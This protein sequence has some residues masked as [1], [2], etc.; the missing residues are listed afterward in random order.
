MPHTEFSV[1]TDIAAAPERVWEVLTDIHGSPNVL[2]GVQRVDVLTDGPYAV[3]TRWRETRKIMGMSGTEEM[4]VVDNEPLRRT[5][6]EARSRGTVYRTEF[7]LEETEAGTSLSMTFGADSPETSG[8]GGLL[9]RVTGPLGE[10]M[11]QR[12]MT[13]DLADIAAAAEQR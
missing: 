3:G 1:S 12:M 10:R 11:S 6:I 7:A 13:S 8:V 9:Q 5:V 4:H 2:S